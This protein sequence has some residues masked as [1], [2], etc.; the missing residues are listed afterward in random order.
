MSP[1]L[2]TTHIRGPTLRQARAQR[3][4]YPVRHHFKIH[5]DCEHRASTVECVVKC[6]KCQTENPEGVKF[7]IEYGQSLNSEPGNFTG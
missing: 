6:P 1:V 7:C 3:G 5:L 2:H 4:Q